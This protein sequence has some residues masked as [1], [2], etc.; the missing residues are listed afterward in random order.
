MARGIVTC[1]GET[2]NIGDKVRTA[3]GSIL[4]VQGA[5]IGVSFHNA[6]TCVVVPSHTKTT[7]E[8]H[9][10]AKDAPGA[11]SRRANSDCIIWGT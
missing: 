9:A 1:T 2:I 8:E 3:D 4:T 6:E 5:A 7:A 11:A 10:E